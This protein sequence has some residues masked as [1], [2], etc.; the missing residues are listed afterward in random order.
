[1]LFVVCYCLV[2]VVYMCVVLLLLFRWPS[3]VARYSLL[4]DCCV[5]CVVR[6]RCF[7]GGRC[8]LFL[9]SC[10]LCIVV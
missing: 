8:L 5:L 9:A 7:V 4:V 10:L 1:M 2:F 3:S 6:P